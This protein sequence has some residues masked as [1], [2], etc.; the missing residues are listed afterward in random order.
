M[1]INNGTET[2]NIDKFATGHFLHTIGYVNQVKLFSPYLEEMRE[3]IFRFKPIYTSDAKQKLEQNGYGKMF[4]T[5]VSVH[6]RMG[7]YQD[8]LH[9]LPEGATSD[10]YSRAMEHFAQKY[11]VRI[12]R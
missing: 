5:M 8:L 7:D 11:S 1:L 10:Y 4:S 3:H 2:N 6:V 9:G 12:R